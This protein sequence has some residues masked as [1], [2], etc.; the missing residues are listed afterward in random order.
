M[1][2]SVNEGM[3]HFEAWDARVGRWTKGDDMGN[4][5]WLGFALFNLFY[6]KRC[7]TVE[8]PVRDRQNATSDFAGT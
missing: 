5:L 3:K 7:N 8:T 6:F 2:T 4:Y 1:T